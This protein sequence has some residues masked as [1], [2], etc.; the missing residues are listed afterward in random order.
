MHRRLLAADVGVAVGLGSSDAAKEAA[1]V[2]LVDGNYSS[3]VA[4]I[5]EGRRIY[6]NIRRAL[7][8][9]LAS[10]FGELGL[11]V[12]RLLAGLAVA[13]ITDPHHLVERDD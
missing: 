6:R 13:V 2:V 10:N 3:I 11:I 8:Y 9:L 5:T 4:A 7:V 1:D 12:W